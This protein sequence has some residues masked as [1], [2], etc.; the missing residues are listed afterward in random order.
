LQ[1][2]PSNS[3]PSQWRMVVLLSV[4][5]AVAVV[6]DAVVSMEI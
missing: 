1:A 2:L 6:S 3:R 5:L 4:G